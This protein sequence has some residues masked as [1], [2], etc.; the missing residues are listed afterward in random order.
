MRSFILDTTRRSALCSLAVAAIAIGVIGGSASAPAHA[1]HGSGTTATAGSEPWT[2]VAWQ[3]TLRPNTEEAIPAYTCPDMLP[4]L[5]DERTDPSAPR[6][7]TVIKDPD[8]RVI[9]G[10]EPVTQSGYVTGWSADA[11]R[12]KALHYD[13][14]LEAGDQKVLITA[15]CTND[16]TRAYRP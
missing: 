11:R 9:L 8:I 1:A 15:T 14:T 12:A 6:G 7:V 2:F 16:V 13:P 4:F 5:V 3:S 10:S